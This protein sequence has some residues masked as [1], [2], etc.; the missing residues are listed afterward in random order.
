MVTPGQIFA[1]DFAHRVHDARRQGRRRRLHA[2]VAG[3]RDRDLIVA[4]HVDDLR[5]H[6]RDR[7]T[8]Q[9]AAVDVRVRVLRQ[10]V[11]RMAAADLGHD[12]RRAQHAVPARIHRPQRSTASSSRG[13]CS[14]ARMSAATSGEASF[15]S[16]SK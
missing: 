13:S 12:A 11:R 6:A 7:H 1:G 14:T 16:A 9:D 3:R 2:G 4:Q 15:D 8:R 5:L 10:R